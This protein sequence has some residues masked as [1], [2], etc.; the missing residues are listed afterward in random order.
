MLNGIW[1]LMLLW[2]LDVKCCYGIWMLMLLWYLDVN[3][4]MV[5]GC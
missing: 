4:A 2:Y 5:S 3:V 1:M